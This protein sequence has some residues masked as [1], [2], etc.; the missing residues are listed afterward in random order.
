MVKYSDEHINGIFSGLADPTRRDIIHRL[1]QK[2][3]NASEIASGYK[4]SMPAVSK[5][6]KVLK[7]ADLVSERK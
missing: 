3:L 2:E 6:L 7:S 1:V 5:H 4:I